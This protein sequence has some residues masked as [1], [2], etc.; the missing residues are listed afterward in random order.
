MLLVIMLL[1]PLIWITMM[2]SAD[3]VVDPSYDRNN[4]ND[5]A[6]DE[7]DDADN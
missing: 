6:D 4:E 3:Y 5:D 2:T 1:I 7:N